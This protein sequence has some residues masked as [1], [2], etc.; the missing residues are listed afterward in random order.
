MEDC[1]LWEGPHS[2]AGEEYEQ[3]GVADTRCDGLTTT[4]I[5][6]LPAPCGGRKETKLG[7]RLSLGSKEGW[8]EGIFK[9]RF[10]FSLSYSDLIGDKLNQFA[11]VET[12]FP[13][14]VTG[15]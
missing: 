8:E 5:P 12:V 3:E 9:I 4:P 10:Y 6:H 11:Q 7:V 14:T 15:E 1:L 2:G 13:M